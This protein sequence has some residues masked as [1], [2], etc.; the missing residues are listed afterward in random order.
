MLWPEFAI[1]RGGELNSAR[2]THDISQLTRPVSF[3]PVLA[4]PEALVWGISSCAYAL[5]Y[6]GRIAQRTGVAGYICQSP[7]KRKTHVQIMHSII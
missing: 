4:R 2:G 3:Q 1:V 7:K 6:G 5:F